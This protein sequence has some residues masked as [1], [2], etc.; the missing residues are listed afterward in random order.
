M[1]QKIFKRKSATKS[2]KSKQAGLQ[3]KLDLV[4]ASVVRSDLPAYRI[5]DTVRVQ[6]KIQEGDKTRL[7]AF[8]GTV[9]G[10]SNRGPN[11]SLTVRK[12]SH[13]VG[14]ER[15]FLENSPKVATLEVIQAGKVRR[16]KLYYLR[17]RAG[18]AAKVNQKIQT[19]ESLAQSEAAKSKN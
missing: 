7:Q 11:R 17:G 3:S 19:N 12:I 10:R 8:E 13:G 9:I 14:V 2:V 1:T 5:G 18:K 4:E 16:A 6:V 15:V